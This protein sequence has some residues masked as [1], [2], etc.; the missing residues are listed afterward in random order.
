[1]VN[2]TTAQPDLEFNAGSRTVTYTWTVVNP[3]GREVQVTL[4]A[5]HDK[6]RKRYEAYLSR[7]II[8]R[9]NGYY[10]LLHRITSGEG[11]TINREAAAR[12]SAK[13]LVDFAAE[14]LDAVQ[15]L[16]RGEGNADVGTNVAA[17]LRGENFLGRED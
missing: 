7:A 5:R 12:Y 3:Y 16:A 6:G 8:E 9:R 1:M 10:T 15:R 11:M 4:T 14:S 13:R 17:L 2:K